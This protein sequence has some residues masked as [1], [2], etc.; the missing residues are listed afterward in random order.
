MQKATD[1]CFLL[2][3]WVKTWVKICKNLSGK[4]IQKLLDHAKESETDSLKTASNRA[5]AKTAE[6]TGNLIGNKLLIE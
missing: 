2:K 4:Y 1:F 5:T 3:I 6:A